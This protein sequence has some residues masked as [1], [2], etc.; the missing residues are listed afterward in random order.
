MNKYVKQK[1]HGYCPQQNEERLWEERNEN[2]WGSQ[3]LLGQK[4]PKKWEVLVLGTLN[5]WT[6]FL[7]WPTFFDKCLVSWFWT[8]SVGRNN[9]WHGDIWEKDKYRLEK[10][11]R[12]HLNFKNQGV[13]GEDDFRSGSVS[14]LKL[15]AASPFH[16]LYRLNPDTFYLEDQSFGTDG[17]PG[18]HED[19]CD[20]A[21]QWNWRYV[22]SRVISED[23]WRKWT[24]LRPSSQI[25][26]KPFSTCPHTSVHVYKHVCMTIKISVPG[27]V[28]IYNSHAGARRSAF[29][30]PS[31]SAAFVSHDGSED[32]HRGRRSESRRC[33][34]R[35][36]GKCRIWI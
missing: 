16:R 8:W 33:Q 24:Q 1:S 29:L 28:L 27:I 36:V 14:D 4:T 9:S 21:I 5:S 19:T 6:R 25:S 31:E 26:R 18:A 15:A 20:T 32:L 7:S 34:K 11:R 13:V 30:S 3:F 23:R 22:P 10:K 12:Q 17:R 35:L 2:L